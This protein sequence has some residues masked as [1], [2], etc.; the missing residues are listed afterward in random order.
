MPPQWQSEE[1]DRGRVTNIITQDDFVSCPLEECGEKVLQSEITEHIELHQAEQLV[2]DDN[3]FITD[4]HPQGVLQPTSPLTNSSALTPYYPAHTY[5]MSPASSP[6]YGSTGS[7]FAA[8]SAH[9]SNSFPSARNTP[10]GSPDTSLSGSHG[11]VSDQFRNLNLSPRDQVFTTAMP[12]ALRRREERPSVRR[13]HESQD[14]GIISWSGIRRKLLTVDK[15]LSHDLD[16]R[17]KPGRQISKAEVQALRLGVSI[18]VM[19]TPFF[20]VPELIIA[21]LTGERTR[22]VC[23]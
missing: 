20:F 19:K 4:R 6:T 10:H 2:L 13:H 16:L 18:A 3:Y 12:N 17:A 14:S 15:W 22:S 21:C 7:S 8:S 11:S 1:R 9:S 23:I 5:D